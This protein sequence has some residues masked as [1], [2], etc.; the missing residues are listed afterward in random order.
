MQIHD[1]SQRG[2]RKLKWAE[3]IFLFKF[4]LSCLEV[5]FFW[6][7]HVTCR[8]FPDQESKPAPAALEVQ[9]LNH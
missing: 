9:N 7:H 2:G 6:L 8:I 5:N 1:A 3:K 4:F